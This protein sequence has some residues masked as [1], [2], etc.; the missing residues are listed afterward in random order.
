MT[1]NNDRVP[2][3]LQVTDLTNSTM[4]QRMEM[5]FSELRDI[6][7]RMRLETL[8]EATGRIVSPKT[9]KR[10]AEW[11]DTAPRWYDP[12]LGQFV[13]AWILIP[14]IDGVDQ[15]RLG[16]I[17]NDARQRVPVLEKYFAAR[18]PSVEF[19]YEWGLFCEAAG[20]A[21]LIYFSST[22]PGRTRNAI[23]GMAC[24]Y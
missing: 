6:V 1:A 14:Y 18:V 4:W 11:R 7:V 20:A 12:E 16:D 8:E 22:R 2:A 13:R 15:E 17:L 21:Q 10:P 24:P 9:K 5:R 3:H 23:A 19:L